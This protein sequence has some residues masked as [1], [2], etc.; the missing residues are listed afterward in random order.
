MIPY[1]WMN[2]M[3]MSM[4]MNMNMMR[5]RNTA[6][7]PAVP[8][9]QVRRLRQQA[10]MRPRETKVVLADGAHRH[11]RHRRHQHHRRPFPTDSEG[12]QTAWTL[13]AT[14]FALRAS[15]GASASAPEVDR[16]DEVLE[17]GERARRKKISEKL[18]GRSS[19]NKG[20]RWSPA[21]VAK[22][23]KASAIAMERPEVK[24]KL[25]RHNE[26]IAAAARA[27]EAERRRVS[28]AREAQRAARARAM[29]DAM[30][31]KKLKQCV[32]RFNAREEALR[33]R[34]AHAPCSPALAGIG[35]ATRHT[36]LARATCTRALARKVIGMLPSTLSRGGDRGGASA[37]SPSH[38]RR[39]SEAIARKWKEQGYRKKVTYGIRRRLRSNAAIKG[40]VR[41]RVQCFEITST[42]T[43]KCVCARACVYLLF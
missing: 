12:G 20:R 39:I 14:G 26:A 7:A 23:R 4:K 36:P 24:E 6:R 8:R 17:E 40:Y 29:R 31:K 16:E 9:Q 30:Y 19:W 41:H 25:A 1:D 15:S 33:R 2:V 10:R 35:S 3:S 42:W 37:L 13:E 21:M 32:S 27:R 11:H 18:K 34:G 43:W 28:A 38:R 22:I 5:M